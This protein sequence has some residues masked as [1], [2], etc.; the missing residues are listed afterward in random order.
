VFF[1]GSCTD[2][3]Y[4]RPSY[5]ASRFI[6]RRRSI[7][8]SRRRDRWDFPSCMAVTG[9][10]QC[11]GLSK[12]HLLPSSQHHVNCRVAPACLRG[13]SWRCRVHAFSPACR[14]HDAWA[15]GFVCWWCRCTVTLGF[16]GDVAAPREVNPAAFLIPSLIRPRRTMDKRAMDEMPS[17]SYVH[18][19]S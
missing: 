16:G 15:R 8:Y 6:G 3:R 2:A 17:P 13:R 19:L 1:F 5:L 4:C 12:A 11:V 10:V 9:T 14:R 18:H 7:Y